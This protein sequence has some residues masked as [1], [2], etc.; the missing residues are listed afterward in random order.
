MHAP[1]PAAPHPLPKF[2]S[3]Q[4]P[5]DGPYLTDSSLP[6]GGE[7]ELLSGTAA[8]AP[9]AS[10]TPGPAAGRPGSRGTHL[11]DPSRRELL[12]QPQHPPALPG[13][14]HA[15]HVTGPRARAS[16]S[17]SAAARLRTGKPRLPRSQVRASVAAPRELLVGLVREVAVLCNLQLHGE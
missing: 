6:G 2:A 9:P 1:A 7:N 17:P 4:Q 16:S 10:E 3:R 13:P 11:E 5:P 15:G 8:A 12:Q 14:P